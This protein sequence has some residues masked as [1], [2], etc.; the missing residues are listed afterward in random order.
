MHLIPIHRAEQ[1]HWACAAL[2]PPQAG[3]ADEA[4]RIWF[5]DSL[6]AER[7]E[8]TT[9]LQN[10]YK[11]LFNEEP[12]VGGADMTPRQENA[13][14]C[15]LYCIEMLLRVAW[16]P[17]LR[18]FAQSMKAEAQF[19]DAQFVRGRRRQY[20]RLSAALAAGLSEFA[21][22]FD[23]TTVPSPLL[24]AEAGDAV[25]LCASLARFGVGTAQLEYRVYRHCASSVRAQLLHLQ[26]VLLADLPNCGGLIRSSVHDEQ[27]FSVVAIY[28]G[29]VV[30]GARFRL[31][32]RCIMLP[33]LSMAAEYRQR[34]LGSRLLDILKWFG[35]YCIVA[36]ADDGALDFYRKNGFRDQADHPVRIPGPAAAQG[37][38][39]L[40][41]S[42]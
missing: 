38:T 31:D 6:L 26:T 23:F 20:G 1:K 12:E 3:N 24:Q 36:D 13:N 42:R 35:P 15:G 16:C 9:K 5:F 8:L 34:G 28:G 39:K 40:V 18:Q 4:P 11:A 33:L 29:Q 10:L 19:L 27:F 30:G 2:F 21:A 32:D 41:F 22:G 14:D 37:A 25:A 7:T 17:D